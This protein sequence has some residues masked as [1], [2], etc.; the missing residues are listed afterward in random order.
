M[1]A[2]SSATREQRTIPIKAPLRLSRRTQDASGSKT[3]QPGK[4]TMLCRKRSEPWREQY[5]SL[6]RA[7]MWS[8]VG[9]VDQLGGCLVVVG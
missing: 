5:W 2:T 6:M 8:E 4:R 1:W 9:L 3:P 7:S